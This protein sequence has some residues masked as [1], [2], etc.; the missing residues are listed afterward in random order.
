MHQTEDCSVCSIVA[1]VD[2]GVETGRFG[3][4]YC[5]S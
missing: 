3:P 5:D 1:T 2:L 4:E